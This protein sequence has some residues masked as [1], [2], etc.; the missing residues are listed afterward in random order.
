MSA[1]QPNSLGWKMA[2]PFGLR[3][4]TL[5]APKRRTNFSTST[6]TIVRCPAAVDA[7]RSRLRRDTYLAA[8]PAVQPPPVGLRA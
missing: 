1:K 5:L 7:R 2:R 4:G 8:F 3:C 6:A